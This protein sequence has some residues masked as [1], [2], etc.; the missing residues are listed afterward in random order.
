MPFCCFEAFLE[1]FI[2]NFSF[3]HK[4]NY[5]R[6]E[7]WNTQK[8]CF[9]YHVGKLANPE[10]NLDL[11]KQ[12]FLIKPVRKDKY[13]KEMFFS[14]REPHSAKLCLSVVLKLFEKIHRKLFFLNVKVTIWKTSTEIL[15]EF[16]FLNM[17]ERGKYCGKFGFI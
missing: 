6:N 9:S 2:E 12:L 11:F 16:V 5:L 13:Y 10:V 7:H 1:K 17:F 3:R 4:I 8:V 14:K 15:R